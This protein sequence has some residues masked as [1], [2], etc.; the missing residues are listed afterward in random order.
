MR[1]SH[2][3]LVLALTA[4]AAVSTPLAAQAATFDYS[5]VENI[6]ARPIDSDH[7]L[8][9]FGDPSDNQG[10]TGFSNLDFTAPD[11]GHLEISKNAPG[12]PAAYYTT[13][14]PRSPEEPATG[15]TRSTSLNDVTGFSNFFSYLNDNS[16]SLST[17]GLSY[18]QKSDRDF[19]D[20]WNLGED[21]LGQ[22]WFASP[23]SNLEER[24]YRA[25]P[26]DVEIFISYED[27]KIINFGYSDFYTIFDYGDSLGV[28]DDF[29][30][31]LTDPFTAD[32]VEG[33]DP[34]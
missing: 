25:N 10:F 7:V 21:K 31:I 16:I 1:K 24:I 26:D 17:I 2:I 13:G 33:L 11:R 6:T 8:N 12:N 32:I 15:A 22:D 23:D 19:T 3:S 34:F 20:T 30:A 4:T 28:T 29:D 18:G 27:T 5:R 14:R 9:F